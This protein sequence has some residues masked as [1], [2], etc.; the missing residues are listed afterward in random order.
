MQ[1]AVTGHRPDKLGGY[2]ADAMQRVFAFALVKLQCLQPSS[3]L[4]GMALGWDT[5][6]AR[7]CVELKIPFTACIP[8]DG[9]SLKWRDESQAE[10]IRLVGAATRVIIV[11][12]GGYSAPKM[13][14]RNQYM[15]DNAECVLSLWNGS[16][17]GTANC[18]I[19]A[20]QQKKPVRSCWE[21]FN[22]FNP[23]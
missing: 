13:Q 18:V 12:T 17:G 4:T 1:I 11:S 23:E 5:A 19:Y 6:I 14:L 9:M 8:F 15:V 2:S 21:S 16:T 22:L 10:F 20:R 3:V 7:A